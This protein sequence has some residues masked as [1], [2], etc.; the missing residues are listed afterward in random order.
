MS[1]IKFPSAAVLYETLTLLG[2]SD[3]V[4][5]LIDCYSVLEGVANT[6]GDVA[7]TQKVK[8]TTMHADLLSS[9]QIDAECGGSACELPIP[10]FS[11]P[12]KQL[13]RLAR[14]AKEA[15]CDA[16]LVLTKDGATVQ[17][18][19]EVL[20]GLPLQR[21]MGEQKYKIVQTD[22]TRE[23]TQRLLRGLEF[24]SLAASNDVTR[25]H[26]RVVHLDLQPEGYLAVT[27]DGHRLHMARL[28]QLSFTVP[29]PSPLAP[30][31]TPDDP[32]NIPNIPIEM[33]PAMLRAMRREQDLSIVG[34][35]DGSLRVEVGS[36]LLE[37]RVPEM[38]FPPWNQVVPAECNVIAKLENVQLL[39]A[40]C[41]L[42]FVDFII[43]GDDLLAVPVKSEGLDT[44][45]VGKPIKIGTCLKG[46]GEAVEQRF[47]AAYVFDALSALPRY[48][49]VDVTFGFN[50]PLDPVS[51][52]YDGLTSII[53]PVRT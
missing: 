12:G 1:Q 32:A 9:T 50:G 51:I 21:S 10:E 2:C 8:L 18:G 26:L 46:S 42:E 43:R 37:Q 3:D 35:S 44:K 4:Q 48:G 28:S 24:V 13:R 15:C 36:L 11:V 29:N 22:G 31:S 39:R 19:I 16:P 53:M 49:G 45:C 52:S 27:T 41:K 7:N 38:R 47:N 20:T 14:L 25:R 6:Q 23:G 34:F 40:A 30:A 17:C 5:L 33:L